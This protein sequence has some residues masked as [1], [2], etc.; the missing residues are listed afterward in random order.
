MIWNV[1]FTIMYSLLSLLLAALPETFVVSAPG[2]AFFSICQ[3]GLWVI[4]ADLV[5][6][7]I[8]RVLFWKS[9]HMV[10]AVVEYIWHH[11]PIIGN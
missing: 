11:L 5:V 8:G 2:S 10:A 4:G 1:L 3:Y 6:V 9:V 7:V